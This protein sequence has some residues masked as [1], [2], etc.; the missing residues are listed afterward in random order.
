MKEQECKQC[1]TCCRKGGPA[2]HFQDQELVVNGTIQ[3]KHLFTIR[4]GEPA[5]DNVYGELKPADSD[6]IKIKGDDNSWTCFFL[7]KTNNLCRIYRNRPVECRALKCWDT[8]QIKEIFNEQRLS[9]ERVLSNTQAVLELVKEHEAR[10]S[11]N[12]IQYLANAF[13]SGNN[14]NAENELAEITGYDTALRQVVTEKGCIDQELTDFLFGRPLSI[15]IAGFG[16]KFR[17]GSLRKQNPHL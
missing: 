11:Y 13:K 5:F 15:T 16:L 14:K 9:R 6:I 8:R 4:K 12:R 17:K 7:N 10:C 2:L 1:G 3:A